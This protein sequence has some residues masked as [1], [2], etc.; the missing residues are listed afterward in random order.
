[1]PV[2][3][4]P[5]GY[6]AVTPYLIVP[7][8][9]RLIDFLKEAFDAIEGERMQTPDGRIMH[10]EVT[11][12][13]SRIMMGEPKAQWVPMPASLHLY[14][15]DIETTY[16]RSIEAGASTVMEPGDQF[17]G[18]RSAGIKDPSGNIWWIATHVE[19]VAPDEMKRHAE[20][21]FKTSSGA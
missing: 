9:A 6:H 3:P 17:Y 4:V 21:Q 5:E 11:I 8:V 13:D 16:R 10:A 2:K 12:G 18:D 20:A 1:M 19:D 15:N 7:G 14:V